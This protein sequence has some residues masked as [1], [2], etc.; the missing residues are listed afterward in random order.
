MNWETLSPILV[1]V[2][3]FAAA[4]AAVASVIVAKMNNNY[5][6]SLENDKRKSE[7]IQYRYTK[8]YSILEDIEN[9]LGLKTYF[10]D[11]NKT[12]GEAVSRR[13]RYIALYR[14]SRPLIDGRLR[15]SLDECYES[16]KKLFELIAMEL[17]KSNLD[18]VNKHL[19]KWMNSIKKFTDSLSAAIQEQIASMME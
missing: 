7:L 12:F 11:M 17:D 16:E 1:S 18:G 13:E 2:G 15:K 5:L 19:E 10:G 6:R 9:E 4:I 14:L 3:V 8:L